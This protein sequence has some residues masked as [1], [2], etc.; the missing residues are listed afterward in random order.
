[1]FYSVLLAFILSYVYQIFQAFFLN[2][3]LRSVNYLFLMLIEMMCL[4]IFP[5][6][7]LRSSHILPII[8][9]PF[10]CKKHVGLILLF[11]CNYQVFTSIQRNDI[12]YK[13][14]TIYFDCNEGIWNTSNMN[15][16]DTSVEHYAFCES[17]FHKFSLL[18][19]VYFCISNL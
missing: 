14:R 7:L 9:S 5:Q 19:L 2:K 11:S 12:I 8:F 13:I 10:F 4:F 16:S 6:K 17:T 1:M 3:C 18:L 15:T